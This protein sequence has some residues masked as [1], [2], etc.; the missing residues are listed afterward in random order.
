MF[1]LDHEIDS[2][3]K[4]VS[5]FVGPVVYT[6]RVGGHEDYY[7]S[8]GVIDVTKGV[9]DVVHNGGGILVDYGRED[10]HSELLES[11][12]AWLSDGI[13]VVDHVKGGPAD[14]K[15]VLIKCLINKQPSIVPP[16]YD[17][18][19]LALSQIV[20]GS[21]FSACHGASSKA[22]EAWECEDLFISIDDCTAV[23]KAH[24][25]RQVTKERF[26]TLMENWLHFT[27]QIWP[28]HLDWLDI[29]QDID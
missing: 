1:R 26:S 6:S 22:N 11:S 18:V 13:Y 14:F 19:V 24:I 2:I 23:S 28:S 9:D 27:I 17:Q 10:T 8:D 15:E 25:C 29:Q 7:I 16:I 4:P 21:H 3:A 12:V 20:R 5:G